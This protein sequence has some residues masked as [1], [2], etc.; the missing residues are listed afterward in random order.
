MA[1]LHA[2]AGEEEAAVGD[3]GHAD[4]DL[5]V[6]VEAAHWCGSPSSGAAASTCASIN[7]IICLLL[8]SSRVK[9]REG[10]VM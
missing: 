8:S 6:P 2:G 10:G 7:S 1:I 3:R 4:V 5:C 9:T